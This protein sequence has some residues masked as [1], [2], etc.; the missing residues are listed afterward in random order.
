M[1]KLMIVESP[2]KIK[3]IS[4][5][6]G[7]GWKVSA[8][9]GHIRDLPPNDMGVSSP[10]FIPNY[11]IN[12]DKK[13]VVDQLKA[14][15][16]S[17]DEVYLA[18]DPDREGEAIAFHL[19][20]CLNIKNPKRVT[21]TEITKSAIEKAL[22]KA[23]VIDEQMVYAQ[24]SRRVVDRLVGYTLSPILS[25]MAGTSLSVGRVQSPA[26]KLVALREKEIRDFVKQDFYSVNIVL[27][28]GIE[29]SLDPK[30]WSED[31][32]HIFNEDIAKDIANT[33]NI[34]VSSAVFEDKE[35][36]PKAPFTTSTLQQAAS[37]IFKISPAN[38]MKL[39][40]SLFE[41]GAI[42]YHRTDTPN[43]SEDSFFL[44][45]QVLQEMGKDTQETQLKW[46]TKDNA[47]EAHE[48]IRPTDLSDADCGDTDDEKRLYRLIRER[49]LA[50]AMPPA[51]DSVTSYEFLSNDEISTNGF[52][53][54]PVFKAKGRVE[55]YKGWRSICE[56]EKPKKSDGELPALVAENDS[57]EVTAKVVKKCT[58]PAARYSEASLIKQL[59]KLGIGRP[60]TYASILENIKYRAY[61][62]IRKEDGKSK[63][64]K[65]FATEKGELLV[66]A[67]SGLAFM[68]FDYTKNL[69]SDLDKVADGKLSYLEIVTGVYDLLETDSKNIAID[70]LIETRDCAFCDSKVKRLESPK[71]KSFFWVHS[72]PNVDCEPTF[73]DNGGEPVFEKKAP[74]IEADCPCCNKK[75][76]RLKKRDADSFFWVHSDDKDAKKCVTFISD[77]DGQPSKE[78]VKPVECPLCKK[79]L[80]RLQK[81]GAD[82]FFWVHTDDKAAKKCKKFISDNDGKPT[83]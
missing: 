27:D 80:K 43:L 17:S 40:Q 52:T 64:E 37:T 62:E 33:K 72:T 79:G 53:G 10:D 48:A 81:K 26:V 66:K 4:S 12:S 13:R 67:L 49:T 45:K 78:T 39:A 50:S 46:A 19:K 57:F 35:A 22:D 8:S 42:S 76:K 14:L 1:T 83:K 38:T 36:K 63:D 9:V 28:N 30:E 51:I 20:D 11:V 15:V 69:E 58:A 55:K 56:I 60:S 6:L 32:T 65:L 61:I 31:G 68:D 73:S 24:E 70:S 77:D 41:K 23:G 16:N 54:K 59:E 75:V 71:Y 82:S 18:T 34:T 2:N 47:Q 44:V 21:F 7:D 5:Y 74:L 25:S 29:A 3:K